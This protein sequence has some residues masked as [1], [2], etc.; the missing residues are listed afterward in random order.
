MTCK[1]CGFYAFT[2]RGTKE[3]VQKKTCNRCGKVH[4]ETE[5]Y[6]IPHTAI[7]KPE[8]A[9]VL[10]KGQK[11]KLQEDQSIWKIEQIRLE[12]EE[13]V[14]LQRLQH[15]EDED[16]IKTVQPSKLLDTKAWNF[17]ADKGTKVRQ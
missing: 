16:L 15:E 10:E 6:R 5:K 4:I 8:Q 11:W 17:A 12:P 3:K 9:T 2:V 13:E 1:R 14:V 7:G